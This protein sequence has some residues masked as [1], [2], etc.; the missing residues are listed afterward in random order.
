MAVGQEQEIPGFQMDGLIDALNPDG[1][2][3]RLHDVKRAKAFGETDSERARWCTREH[4][5]AP[6]AD[7]VEDLGKGIRR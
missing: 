6:D 5:F 3:A 7:D 4:R 1:D 2:R